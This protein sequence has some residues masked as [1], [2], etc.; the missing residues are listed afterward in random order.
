MGTDQEVR[1][2]YGKSD[3]E[4]E[5]QEESKNEKLVGNTIVADNLNEGVGR[6]DSELK[7]L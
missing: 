5:G 2:M 1:K 4:K 7:G 3:I 6:K